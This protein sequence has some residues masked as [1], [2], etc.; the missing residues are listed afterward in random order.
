MYRRCRSR[1]LKSVD[2]RLE[3][4]DSLLQIVDGIVVPSDS[5]NHFRFSPALLR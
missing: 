4:W 5:L 2:L 3:A 1:G